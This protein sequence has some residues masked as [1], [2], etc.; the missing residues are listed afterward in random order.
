[1]PLVVVRVVVAVQEVPAAPVVDVAVAVVVDAVVRASGAVLA[2]VRPHGRRAVPPAEV[3]M[4][5]V[6]AR[7]DD[8]DGHVDAGAGRRPRLERVDVRIRS[9]GGAVHDLTEV[10]QRPEVVE[11]RVVGMI[12]VVEQ[13][14]HAVRLGVP[15][16]RVGAQRVERVRPLTV[17]RLA[18]HA[19]D[20]VERPLLLHAGASQRSVA[21]LL[22]HVRPEADEQLIRRGELSRRRVLAGCGRCRGGDERDARDGASEPGGGATPS[23][24]GSTRAHALLPSAPR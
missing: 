16:A 18:E 23:P 22:A 19:V 20:P 6:D 17:R 11:P 15:N 12:A 8:A 4:G 13:R 21:S 9:A 10:V 3:R 7:V 14:Y 5:K 1:V 2:G 24:P